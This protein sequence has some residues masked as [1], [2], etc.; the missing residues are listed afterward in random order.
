MKMA[1]A[2][3]LWLPEH[4]MKNGLGRLHPSPI[5]FDRI[6]ILN[7]N[8]DM[9]GN[10]LACWMPMLSR[11]RSSFVVLSKMANFESEAEG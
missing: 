5:Q 6:A 10:L 7:T 1:S 3:P 2:D 9:V 11:K 8:V 4:L